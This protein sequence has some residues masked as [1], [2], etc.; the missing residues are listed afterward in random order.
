MNY[1]DYS[2]YDNSNNYS[3]NYINNFIL[4]GT[5][6]NSVFLCFISTRMKGIIQ[7]IKEQ[8]YIK[9]PIYTTT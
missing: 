8:N 5:I 7:E 9:P 2:N 1:S 6:I 3:Y 4:F